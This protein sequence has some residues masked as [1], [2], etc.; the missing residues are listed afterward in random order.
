MLAVVIRAE[1]VSALRED[2][3]RL[4]RMVDVLVRDS[5]T[6]SSSSG[7]EVLQEG[8]GSVD[9]LAVLV[10]RLWAEVT[11][12]QHVFD[13]VHRAGA[14]LARITDVLELQLQLQL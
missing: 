1:G 6:S 2:E 10:M 13:I 7:P 12:G 11:S 8:E 5:N 14:A 3:K 9:R 4:L